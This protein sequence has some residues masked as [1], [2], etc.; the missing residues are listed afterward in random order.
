MAKTAPEKKPIRFEVKRKAEALVF[1]RRETRRVFGFEQRV[2]GTLN[3]E[4][5]H[6]G[7]K[8]EGQ[9]KGVTKAYR[10]AP[11]QKNIGK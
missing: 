7:R 3:D 1:E 10:T 6:E 11:A 8:G 5:A 9:E 2:P 4:K